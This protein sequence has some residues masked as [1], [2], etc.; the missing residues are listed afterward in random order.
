[1]SIRRLCCFPGCPYE[2]LPGKSFCEHHKAE[3]DK[4][5][6]KIQKR[7]EEYFNNRPKVECEFYQTQRWKKLRAE[8][9]ESHPYCSICGGTDKLQV[10]HTWDTKEY[11]Q[12]A[13][14]FFDADHLQVV[15]HEC[16]YQISNN[17]ALRRI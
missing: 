9:L 16:H 13:D 5:D 17:K 4:L 14:M 15:C 8:I 11:L 10:H 2:R 1:M 7:K 12:N 6:A 3:Q